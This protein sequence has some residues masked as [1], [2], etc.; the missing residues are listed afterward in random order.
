[1]VIDRF[2]FLRT[3]K[4]IPET[5]KPFAVTESRSR[6]GE[7]GRSFMERG[8]ISESKSFQIAVWIIEIARLVCVC[9]K[10]LIPG[11]TRMSDDEIITSYSLNDLP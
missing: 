1:M 4:Q 5:S 11:F 9:Q 2:Q 3:L 10:R 7:R 6:A 8:L